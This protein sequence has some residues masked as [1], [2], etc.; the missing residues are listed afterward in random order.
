[1]TTETIC[2]CPK[3]GRLHK[4]LQAGMPP[5]SRLQPIAPPPMPTIANPY[6][7]LTDKELAI[8]YAETAIEYGKLSIDCQRLM[9]ENH[10]LR[11]ER[12]RSRMGHLIT[13]GVL[14]ITALCLVWSLLR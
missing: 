13:S 8:T 4:S 11:L 3:C 7:A 2:E 5:A 9:R 14:I 12:D 6:R 10:L 1:M